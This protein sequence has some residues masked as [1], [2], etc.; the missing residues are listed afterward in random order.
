MSQELLKR[1]ESK[2]SNG[3]LYLGC[4]NGWTYEEDDLFKELRSYSTGKPRRYSNLG[5]CYNQYW[6]EICLE[7]KVF[8]ITYTVDSGD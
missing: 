7:G 2:I 4:A 3:E 5:R 8:D 1:I 6:I